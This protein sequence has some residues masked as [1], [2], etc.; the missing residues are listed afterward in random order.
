MP[1]FVWGQGWCNWF[2]KGYIFFWDYQYCIPP[3]TCDTLTNSANRLF[4]FCSFLHTDNRIIYVS[5]SISKL[6]SVTV[7][8]ICNLFKNRN[9][10]WYFRQ[11][12]GK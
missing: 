4:D 3:K 9:R 11:Q 2:H 8:I 6:C 5:Y 1:T 10:Y 12:K 7:H